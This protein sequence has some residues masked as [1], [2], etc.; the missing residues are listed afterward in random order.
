MFVGIHASGQ[1]IEAVGYLIRTTAVYGSGK[2]GAA[3]RLSIA[4]RPEV[5][6]P[7]QAEMLSVW[8]TRAFSLD[9]V[10]HIAAARGGEGVLS[11]AR[12]KNALPRHA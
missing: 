10:E 4:D 1:V 12:A 7:F 9:L 8:L 11:A 5:S 6:G 3:D 2:F